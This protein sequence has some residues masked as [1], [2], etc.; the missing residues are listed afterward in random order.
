[1]TSALRIV[2]ALV[3]AVGCKRPLLGRQ[4]VHSVAP[5]LTAG[6]F[7]G[8]VCAIDAPEDRKLYVISVNRSVLRYRE[9]ALV[10]FDP[11]TAPRP[12]SPR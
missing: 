8:P 3:V 12:P 6:D 2:F 7:S 10:L 4:A 1:M 9:Y 5:K 11:R